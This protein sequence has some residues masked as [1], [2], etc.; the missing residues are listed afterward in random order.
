MFGFLSFVTGII[1]SVF[2][3]I[4]Y[5]DVVEEHKSPNYLIIFLFI[6]FLAL[7]FIFD[8]LDDSPNYNHNIWLPA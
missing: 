8:S 6:I 5:T 3:F 2:G 4:I 7:T 1:S